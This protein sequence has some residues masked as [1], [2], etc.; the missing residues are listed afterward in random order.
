[1]FD[2]LSDK[3]SALFSRMA[4]GGRLTERSIDGALTLVRTHLFEADVPHEVVGQFI[5]EVKHAIVGQKISGSTK[6][7]D[8]FIKIIY[9]RLVHFLSADQQLCTFSKRATVVMMGLQGSGKTT[10]VTKL[11][12][13]MR[14]RTP[15]CNILL[16][17]VDFVRP[18]AQEQ[19]EILAQ[20]LQVP[21]YRAAYADPIEA[22]RDIM[23]EYACG[24]YDVLILDTAGR[25]HVDQEQLVQLQEV[26]ALVRPTHKILVLDAMTGQESLK[27]AHAFANTADFD[28]ALLTKTDS[29]TRSGAAFAFAYVLKKPIWFVGTG[30]RARDLESFVPTRMATRILGMGDLDALLE[31]AQAVVSQ[32]EQERLARAVMSG[33]FTLGDFAK[34]IDMVD[35][36]GSLQSLMRYLPG[37]GQMAG[38]LTPEKIEQGQRQAKRFRVIIDSMTP[39]ERRAPH[40]LNASR[41]ARIACGAGVQVSDVRELVQRFNQSKDMMRVLKQGPFG[42]LLR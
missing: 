25:M 20:Q 37:M 40:I 36:I 28:G 39:K 35:K 41:M 23:R 2:F 29:D 15:G 26:C 22:T 16:S 7:G 42:R 10:S 14:E 19:L 1:M 27:V 13:L 38:T 12:R 17:S 9:E 18:A 33:D 24:G 30:E 21:F 32:S 6:P 8:V 11:A 3:F 4:N 5:D 34:Q 31:R